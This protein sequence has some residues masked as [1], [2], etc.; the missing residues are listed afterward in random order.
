[1]K[2]IKKI[3]CRIFGH[4]MFFDGPSCVGP[5]TCKRCG[6]KKENKIYWYKYINM[7]IVKNP[8]PM[9]KDIVA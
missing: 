6:F 8:K 3:I 7:L 4:R 5:S 2:R 1:M 9:I